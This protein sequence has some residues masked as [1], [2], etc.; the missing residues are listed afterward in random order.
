MQAQIPSMYFF[1]SLDRV[2]HLHLGSSMNR[3][4]YSLLL[5]FKMDVSLSELQELV[6]DREAWRAAIH[7]V[8]K[9]WTRLSDWTELNW[10]TSFSALSHILIYQTQLNPNISTYLTFLN[11]HLLSRFNNYASVCTLS[12]IKTGFTT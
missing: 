2:Y 8:A 5:H 12:A 1:F 4:H 7:G 6:M 11:P 9:S 10:T 3:L